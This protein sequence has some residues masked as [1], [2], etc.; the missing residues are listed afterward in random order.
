M[1]ASA[2]PSATLWPPSVRRGDFAHT[3]CYCE[4]NV[5]LLCKQ[6]CTSGFSDIGGLD[7]FVVFISNDRKQAC[8]CFIYTLPEENVY[9]LCKQLCTSGFSDIGGLDLFVVFI[10]NDRKQAC[11]CFIYTLLNYL[12]TLHNWFIF[13]FRLF[14]VVHAPLFLHHFAS[15]RRHMKDADGNWISP[16]PTSNPIVSVAEPTLAGLELCLRAKTGKDLGNVVN[17]PGLVVGSFMFLCHPDG[18][19]N[20][21]DQYIT[22]RTEEVANTVQDALRSVFLQPLGVVVSEAQLEEFFTRIPLH[23]PRTNQ[24]LETNP[25]G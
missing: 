21:L 13:V 14:R 4:E 10:S 16:P 1:S 19:L 11:I 17:Q 9:L 24:L 18:I 25:L 6:L 5:Y 22:I 20:N 8:I 7:L 15:D 12:N 23:Q 3:P 2:S